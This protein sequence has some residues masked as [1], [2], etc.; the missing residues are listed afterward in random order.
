M[1]N[2]GNPDKGP[3]MKEGEHHYDK[4]YKTDSGSLSK[5]YPV[6]GERGNDYKALQ[7]KAQNS[8]AKKLAANK[9]SKV[10]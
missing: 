6:K 1:V 5:G 8:D 2:K 10:A 4:G 7:D 3:Q 9:F